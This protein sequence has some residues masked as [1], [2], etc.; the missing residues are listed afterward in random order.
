MGH[1]EAAVPESA[2]SWDLSSA[3]LTPGARCMC[4]ASEL[5]VWVPAGHPHYK[6]EAT[7]TSHETSHEFCSCL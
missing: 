5:S 3:P 1:E 7:R 6:S 2:L 4:Q